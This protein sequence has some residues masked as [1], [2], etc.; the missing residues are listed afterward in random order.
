MIFGQYITSVCE[1][2]LQID[3][4]ISYKKAKFEELKVKHNDTP[5]HMKRGE[6]DSNFFNSVSM[7]IN[8]Q[9]E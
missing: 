5:S 9:T 8:E 6:C 3:L 2:K 1:R 4:F 7:G